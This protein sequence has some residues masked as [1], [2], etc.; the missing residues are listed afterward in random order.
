MHSCLLGRQMGGKG[1]FLVNLGR[2]Q[3]ATAIKTPNKYPG[4]P[5]INVVLVGMSG[6]MQ[7]VDWEDSKV[8]IITPHRRSRSPAE[9][10]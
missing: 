2:H 3:D 5:A 10:S 9:N 6:E 1:T 8:E 7:G 4:F